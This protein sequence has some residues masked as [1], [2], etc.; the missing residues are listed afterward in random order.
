MQ[1]AHTHISTMAKG[2][3]ARKK[4]RRKDGS[5]IPL[6]Y[7][8]DVGLKGIKTKQQGNSGGQYGGNSNS[9]RVQLTGAEKSKRLDRQARFASTTSSSNN[10]NNA[11]D[12]LMA[13]LAAG[14][15]GKKRK[16]SDIGTNHQKKGSKRIKSL[17]LVGTNTM[18]EKEYLRLTSFPK[19]EQVRPLHILRQSLDHVK[20]KYVQDED[21]EWTNTQLKS[22]RQDLTVQGIRE[23]FVLDVYETH[24][25]LL[26]EHGDLNEFNQC[27]SMIK[28]LTCTGTN[29]NNSDLE[30][31]DDS[32][33]RNNSERDSKTLCQSPQSRDE[34]AA[35]Q[36]LYS[37]VL[38]S[39]GSLVHTIA[40]ARSGGQSQ[41]HAMAVARAMIGN[42]HVA[43]FRL[44][45]SAPHLSAYLMDFL[46][47]R[48]RSNAVQQMVAAHRPT[49][50]ME[51]IQQALDFRDV[52]ET[53]Q[54]LK[55][56]KDIVLE[57][58][59]EHAEGG[60]K[61]KKK[62]KRAYMFVVDCKASSAAMNRAKD[63]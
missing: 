8:K 49:L 15:G 39:S 38:K 53:Y 23:S 55:K 33:V 6:A 26:L 51:Y 46:V 36:I 58:L 29:D 2:T 62:K 57:R 4:Q 24:A 44:Y 32:F 13:P 42:N 30:V 10:D 9:F 48:V 31:H 17:S 11:K 20:A 18:L 40:Q 63:G 60:K 25:R 16:E 34:F 47:Q 43:F 3:S 22:I 54:F 21:F 12:N 27:Q 37:L 50:T 35:Y 7:T 19:A 5:S 14:R 28:S 61:K 45:Q 1:D 56:R 59:K 52:E 41:E